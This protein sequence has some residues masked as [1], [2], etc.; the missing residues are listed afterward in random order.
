MKPVK[1]NMIVTANDEFFSL[2]CRT[3]KGQR[4]EVAKRGSDLGAR[5]AELFEDFVVQREVK[6]NGPTEQAKS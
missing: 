6:P 2:E 1:L 5:L 4:F 3:P